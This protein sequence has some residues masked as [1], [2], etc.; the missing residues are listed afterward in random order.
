[1]LTL[2]LCVLDYSLRHSK[3]Q[4]LSRIVAAASSDDDDI[5]VDDVV[6]AIAAIKKV[7]VSVHPQ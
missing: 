1:M 6:L 7:T 4:Q 3:H 5:N 2:V